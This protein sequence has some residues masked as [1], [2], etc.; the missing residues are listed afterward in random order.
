MIIFII[1]IVV[2]VRHL[3]KRSKE[4]NNKAG[5]LQ[6][7]VNI[8]SIAFL[9]G[10]TWLFGAFT[11]VNADQA[12]QILFTLVN[13][14]QGFL[15][16]I[17][18]CLLNSDVRL[19]WIQNVLVKR[20]KLQWSSTVSTKQTTI[21]RAQHNKSEKSE[22]VFTENKATLGS[23]SKLTCT[24]FQNKCHMDEVVEVTFDDTVEPGELEVPESIL[25]E[26]IQLPGLVAKLA[27]T[28]S[29]H[30]HHDEQEANVDDVE[31]QQLEVPEA[32]VT[33]DIQSPG[34]VTML[35]RT[36]SQHKRHMEEVVQ[37]K[38]DEKEGVKQSEL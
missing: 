28:F 16:F 4:R 19:A 20:L 25:T 9:F 32:T 23:P 2:L 21:S 30:K 17:F 1:V 13:S 37:L 38:I 11:V 34:L 26:N 8:T 22:S 18:F 35:T 24:I 27:R 14:F 15:I 6:L 12:F 31:L 3:R 36:F 29:Q 10:L 5:N 7:M 33:K